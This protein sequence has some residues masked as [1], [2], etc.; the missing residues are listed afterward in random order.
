MCICSVDKFTYGPNIY[1]KLK[2][3]VQNKRRFYNHLRNKLLY[4][5]KVSLK[6][7]VHDLLC[8]HLYYLVRKK[9]CIRVI[10]LI[11]VW[12]S[13]VKELMLT[14]AKASQKKIVKWY[15]NYL[16]FV[17]LFKYLKF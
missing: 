10:V 8:A 13:I 15:M 9:Y 14:N 1:S 4:D 16:A 7:W 17:Y 2:T 12:L 3:A 6:E 5:I 11:L